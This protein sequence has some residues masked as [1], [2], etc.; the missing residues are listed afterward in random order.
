MTDRSEELMVE[1]R[2]AVLEITLNRPKV[3]AIDFTLSRMLNDAIVT[4]AMIQS[5]RRLADRSG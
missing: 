4:L 1:R 3:N 2:G 5:A